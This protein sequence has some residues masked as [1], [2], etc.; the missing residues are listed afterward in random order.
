MTRTERWCYRIIH[1][2]VV[3]RRGKKRKGYLVVEIA[4]TF[5]LFL[6]SISIYPSFL[7]SSFYLLLS[8]ASFCLF[9]YIYI[10]YKTPGLVD[11]LLFH[12]HVIHCSFSCTRSFNL[13]RNT[14]PTTQTNHKIIQIISAIVCHCLL[15][16]VC[17]VYLVWVAFLLKIK[18]TNN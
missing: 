3:E 18:I 13:A 16:H 1:W 9:F 15:F 8:I 5:Y 17:H 2:L 12:P 4:T 11:L 10:M 6:H 14:L 7:L